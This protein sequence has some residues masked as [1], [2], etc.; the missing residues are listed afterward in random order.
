[1]KAKMKS[2][3]KK[4]VLWRLVGLSIDKFIYPE[5][6]IFSDKTEA[7]LQPLHNSTIANLILVVLVA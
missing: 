2:Y 3:I 1:M 5:E 7:L 4:T 6:S